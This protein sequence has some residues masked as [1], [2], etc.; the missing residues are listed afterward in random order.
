MSSKKIIILIITKILGLCLYVNAQI[1]APLVYFDFEGDSGDQ[2]IDKGINGNHGN[3]TKPDQTILGDDGAPTGPSPTTG[4]NLSDGLIEVPGVDLSDV[5]RGEGSYT[6]S[7][8]IKPTDLNGDKFL[9]GQTNQGIHNGIRNNGYLHQAHWSADTDGSTLLTAD[10]WVHAAFT[11]DGSTDTGTIYLNGE[12]DWTGQKN[13]PNGGG[14]FIIGNSPGGSGYVGLA[15]EI[16]IWKEVLDEEAVRA[17]ADGAS[18]I[19]KEDGDKDGLPDFYEESLVDNLEDLNGSLDGPGPGSG[20]GDF[21][22][23]GLSDLEEYEEMKTNPTKKDTDGDGLND[24]VE[25]NTGEWVSVSNTG[26]DPLNADSDDDNIVDGVENP[27]LPYNE[28]DP[29]NQPGSDP[30]SS[31]TDG[32]GVLDGRELILE[33]NPTVEDRVVPTFEGPAPL[34][35]F[36]FEG[37]SGDQVI[38]KGING[39][40]GNITKPDQTILGDDGA[41]IG[42]SPTTGV[43]LSDGL[44]EVP[45]VDLIDVTR[46]EGSYTM[47][48]WI[49][50]TDLNGDKFLFGQ[51]DEGIHNGIRNNGYLHQAHW[52]A[53]TNGST[54]LTADEWVH[55]AFTYDGSTDRGTIY[56]NGEV[57]WTGQKRA[58]NGGG[59]FIIGGSPGGSGYVG[60]ADEIAIWKEVLDEEAVRALADGASPIDK[61]IELEFI[62][63]IYSAENDGF[64]MQWNSKPDK[65][66][67]L[68]FS[69]TLESFDEEIEDSIESQ[70]D[71]TIYP[72][73]DEWFPNPLE[74]APRLFFR[75]EENQ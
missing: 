9:F 57:D 34:V 7:A 19:D 24:D 31:D 37:D 17:L 40:H 66:Y 70:G 5:T 18:P 54:L 73:E 35:Y 22:G 4:V 56:L 12:V 59:T 26:T 21:D 47:S 28:E 72:S 36:D 25:T 10:E 61:E 62:S 65:T 46:G 60:L 71:K 51:T 1:P 45:G 41:P 64:R 43:N 42:P 38:D 11:Y 8:W 63:I 29:E 39:N 74:G 6:M 67:I 2:V 50:P 55:A 52:G 20:T 32:D 30:N 44:I 15:D 3:I 14:T 23:D 16:A 13:A 49:K 69:E 27:D 53:D 58:P 75:I 68:L 48:A 33:T